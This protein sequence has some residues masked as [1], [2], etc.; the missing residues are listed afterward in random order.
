MAANRISYHLNFT[1][2]SMAI[3]TACSS[4]LMAVHQACMA[5]RS[6]DTD[7]VI[8]AGANLLLPALSI[9][10]TQAGLSAPTVAVSRSVR[11][12][13]IGRGKGGSG[14]VTP[15]RRCD[16]RRPTHLCGGEKLGCQPRWAQQ[17]D[18]RAQPTLAG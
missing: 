5:L 3:D 8:A 10:Y 12:D 9:F 2:P 14:G 17:R 16:C 4:S 15:P 11:A 13:G 6:G 18:H 1:G 7:T